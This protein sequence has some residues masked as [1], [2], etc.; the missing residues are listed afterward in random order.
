MRRFKTKMQVRKK[1]SDLFDS[2]R[3]VSFMAFEKLDRIADD[4]VI[5]GNFDYV[6]KRSEKYLQPQS[7]AS[8]INSPQP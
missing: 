5:R 7:D 8:L 6:K 1:R 3:S 4:D 2:K